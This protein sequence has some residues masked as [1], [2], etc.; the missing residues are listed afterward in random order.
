M[1]FSHRPSTCIRND[2][3]SVFWKINRPHLRRTRKIWSQNLDG[4]CIVKSWFAISSYLLVTLCRWFLSIEKS[5]QNERKIHD[6]KVNATENLKNSTTQWN[7]LR[8]G[9]LKKRYVKLLFKGNWVLYLCNFRQ[10]NKFVHLKIHARNF[11]FRD[12]NSI[13]FM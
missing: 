3:L 8:F 12:E 10:R 4:F 5:W 2:P 7:L 1:F 11:I 6:E 13:T 9:L